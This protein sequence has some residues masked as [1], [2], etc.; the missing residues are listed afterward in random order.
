M[1]ED[2]P[3]IAYMDFGNDPLNLFVDAYTLTNGDTLEVFELTKR[4]LFTGVSI[5]ILEPATELVLKPVTNSKILFD[6]VLCDSRTRRTYAVNSGMLDYSTD[7]DTHS[8][9]IDDPDFFGFTIES[10]AHNLSS[11]SIKIELVVSDE[12]RWHA[13]PNYIR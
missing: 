5:E 1:P 6:E 2:L 9:L 8:R 11:L 3:Y 12:Y 10:G 7:I 13:T 4:V